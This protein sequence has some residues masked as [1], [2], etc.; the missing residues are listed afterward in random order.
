MRNKIFTCLILL[1]CVISLNSCVQGDIDDL[2]NQIDDLTTTV[3]DLKQAQQEALLAAIASLEASLEN[4]N[5]DL[6]GDLEL[7][8]QEIKNNANAVYYGNVITDAD[9]TALTAQDATIIT[10]R[11]VVASDSQVQA[12]ANVKL[13]GKSLEIMGGGTITMDAL[14]SVGENLLVSGLTDDATLD[15]SKLSSVGGDFNVMSTT[16]LTSIMADEIVLISGNLS[17][18]RNVALTTFSLAKLDKVDEIYI[19]EQV[20]DNFDNPAGKLASL[21]LSST[22]VTNGVE[23]HYLGAVENLTIGSVGGDLICDYS[24]V[25]KISLD[26][27]SIGGD[28][29]L[30]SN[31]FLASIDVPNLSRIE[32]Q[33][34]MTS[35]YDWATPGSG[36]VTMPS[37]AALT[38]IGGDV[39]ISNNASLTTVDAFNS[40]TEIRG[41]SID[42]SS[43]GNLDSVSIFNA[44]VDT[45]DPASQWGDYSHA[46]VTVIANTFWFNGFESLKEALN[47][48][49]NVSKTAGV[50]NEVTGQFE[51][52]GDTAKL[53]GFDNLTDVSTLTLTVTQVTEFD[54]FAALN[55]FKNFQT[56]LTIAMPE[57]ATVSLC[58]MSPVLTRIKNGDF[59]SS[60]NADKKAVFTFNWSEVDRDTAIDQL[61][62]SCI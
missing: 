61:I 46:S 16:G 51:P 30:E 13:I 57:D 28:L 12:L 33:L 8:E 60:W 1:V 22:N 32:G 17:S 11:V 48:N 42:F 50:F 62:G 4:L 37:F 35:N 58:S 56:Y 45:A 49:V 9:Y 43:N 23:I 47:V 20:P 41:S 59:D 31:K 44:L 2:Q 3:A 54:A 5:N 21:D 15:F 18:V 6:I 34:R 10:G 36:L 19:D 25:A 38:Y 55:N 40:V 29:N 39:Y 27:T 26:G 14:Q 52:G 53:E 24:E 7:L